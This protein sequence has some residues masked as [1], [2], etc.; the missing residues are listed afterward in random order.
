MLTGRRVAL[1]A[2]VVLLSGWGLFNT[3]EPQR[4]TASQEN[5]GEAVG[6]ADKAVAIAQ[7]ASPA[8]L[9]AVLGSRSGTVSP[10]L[11]RICAGVAVSARQ[12][13][14]AAH[15]VQA[16]SDG[17]YS[18]VLT[19]GSLCHVKHLDPVPVVRVRTYK[20][21][22]L[23]I[24]E[25]DEPVKVRPADLAVGPHDVGDE[26]VSIGWG[27]AGTM[28]ADPCHATAAQLTT[29]PHESCVAGFLCLTTVVSGARGLCV[30][31]SGNPVIDG[32]LV[33]AI[34]SRTQGCNVGDTSMHASIPG[35]RRWLLR[36]VSR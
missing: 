19:Q 6:Q 18:V 1:G 26:L 36:H 32:R 15:C 14:T 21:R 25:L 5:A 7:R 3:A 4:S 13:L 35:A 27:R 28:G 29:E 31:D 2:A 22:D 12:V 24:L 8:Y 10:A 30:G 20:S 17:N 16:G 33:I 11:T 23:A 9:A 34:G